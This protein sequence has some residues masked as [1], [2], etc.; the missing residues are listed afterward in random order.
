MNTKLN[1][2]DDIVV[3]YLET[4]W[5][6]SKP[7][8]KPNEEKLHIEPVQDNNVVQVNITPNNMDV[9]VE[10]NMVT[11]NN[12][13]NKEKFV[14]N[15]RANLQALRDVGLRVYQNVELEKEVNLIPKT[16]TNGE[17]EK[18]Y[19]FTIGTKLTRKQ[20]MT[21]IAKCTLFPKYKMGDTTKPENFR[22]LVN[23]HNSIKIIDRMWCLNL[24]R[25][26]G[27]NLPDKE[28]YKA[29]LIKNYS[30]NIINTAMNNTLSI[31]GVVLLD[32]VRAFDS[33]EWDVLED[34]L[35][36]NIE[37]KVGSKEIAKQMVDQYMVVLKNREL[38]YNNK[39]VK[40]SKGIPTGLPSSSLVFT[41]AL[42]E[43]L[44]R[45]FMK[46]NYMNKREFNMYVYVDDIYM[47]ILTTE[48]ANNIVTSLIDHLVFYKLY[49][50]KKKSKADEKLKLTEIVNSLTDKDYYLGIP[51]TRDIALYGKLILS[52]FQRNKINITWNEIYEILKK[53]KFD[54]KTRIIFGFMNYKLKPLIQ[55]DTLN[56]TKDIMIQFIEKHYVINKNI[57]RYIIGGSLLFAYIA[58]K[59]IYKRGKIDINNN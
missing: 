47:K 46:N 51:F 59:F 28:I 49:V 39:L 26:C 38:Y 32:V 12:T 41:L 34:L 24:V 9:K 25:L 23:H 44:Y 56:L 27:E 45:W 15:V 48:I 43:I 55:T 19:D 58:Y 36:S 21:N 31:D 29:N 6:S 1:A 8:E 10:I 20:L 30:P 3:S 5:Q 53:D 18:V 14:K 16:V 50:N 37:R 11:N 42:E 2:T 54:E 13:T 33:L 17:I 52:E 57:Y 7:V 22:Y 40:I 4:L 35:L